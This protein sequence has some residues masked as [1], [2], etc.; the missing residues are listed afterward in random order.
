MANLGGYKVYCALFLFCVSSTVSA[1]AQTFTT[2]VSLDGSDGALSY[3]GVVQATNG[4]FYGTT[5]N[6]GTYGYGTVFKIT[7]L[8]KLT[9]LYSF[10]P[11]GT[12]TDGM[13]PSS[14]LVQGANG[15]FYGTTFYG[16]PV[17][18]GNIFEITPTG[19]L[20]PIYLFCTQKDSNGNCGDGSNPMPGLVLANDANFY[21]AT[22]LGGDGIGSD[23]IAYG[24][25]GTIFK[26]SPAGQLTT[27]HSFCNQ[28]NSRGYCA[29]G[30]LPEGSLIQAANGNLYGTTFYGGANNQGTVFEIS[31]V[32][33]LT[34]LY[35]FCAQSSCADGANPK[36]AL[37]QAPDGKFYGTTYGGGAT[38]ARCPSGCG[39]V[40]EITPKG[41]VTTLHA[42]CAS[43]PCPDGAVAQTSLIQATNG[44]LYGTTV[45]GGIPF[46]AGTIFEITPNGALTTLH[47]FDYSD[48]QIPNGALMQA[49]DGNIY[50]TTIYGGANS[51]GTV[52]RL[53]SGLGPFV[54][55][56]PSAGKAGVTI[57]IL[58]NG[59]SGSTAVTFNG[60]PATFKV[61]SN[62]A[63]STQVPTGATTGMIQVTTPGGILTSNVPFRIR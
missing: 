5:Y 42:F 52:F 12:C 46:S 50:G 35:S 15:N 56:Q 21:G 32:G 37:V 3:A 20:T 31:P 54:E 26:M 4:S 28:L 57:V 39:T 2:L 48:G 55:P 24:G 33:N 53:V 18:N 25:C 10:C 61:L 43:G 47:S 19:Q 59:L 14:S 22:T 34:V 30:D 60:T 36:S 13:Y 49:T 44:N 9:T 6:G 45:Q 16:G 8:G 51:D 23:C 63:I 40:F 17:G 38:N 27:L 7:S 11:T 58:G 1:A 29:D 62:A 41:Q